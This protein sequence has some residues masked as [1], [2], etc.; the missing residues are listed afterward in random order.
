MASFITALL[1]HRRL[2]SAA[3]VLSLIC[4][5]YSARTIQV[6]FQFRDFYDH[7]SNPL[8][9]MFKQH[10]EEFGDPAGY[11]VAMVEADDVFRRDILEYVRAVT[12]ALEPV[13]EYAQVISLSNTNAIR[14]DGDDVKTGPLLHEMPS[15]DAELQKLKQTVLSDPTLVRRLVSADGKATAILA[16]MRVPAAFANTTEQRAAIAGVERALAQHPAP[17]G[18]NVRLTGAPVLEAGT[19]DVLTRD[20]LILTPIVCF[21]LGLMLFWTFR[22]LHGVLLCLASVTAAT[23]WAAGIFATFH[24]PIDVLGSIIPTT[25]LV[26]GVVDPIFVLARFLNKLD[27]G[28]SQRDAIVQSY[29]ELGLPCF[30]TS[31]ATAIGFA[32]FVTSVSPGIRYYGLT[33]AIGVMLTFVTTVTVL[34][35]LLWFVPAPKQRFNAVTSTKHVNAAL[36]WMWTKVSPRPWTASLI[37]C[38][39]LVGLGLLAK[40]QQVSN[41]YINQLAD[42]PLR[43]DV[44]AFEDKLTGVIRAAVRLEAGPDDFKKPEVLQA[45]AKLQAAIARD[46]L[47]TFIA[48]PADLVANTHRAFQGG[49]PAAREV[50]SSRTLTAQ[51]LA[52]ID[53]KDRAPL[54]NSDY[55]HAQILIVMKDRGSASVREFAA[56]LERTVQAADLSSVGVRPIITG[57]SIMGYREMDRLVQELLDGFVIAFAVAILLQ[58]I[59]F[60]S[61]RVALISI[62]PN[63]LPLT[64]GFCVTRLS[65][66]PLRFDS[67]LVLCVAIGGLFNTTIHL[68]SRVQ[69]QVSN[70]ARDPDQIVLTALR[71]VGTPSLITAVTLSAGFVMFTLSEFPG[72]RML[73]VL[74]MLTF[75]VGFVSDVVF[76]SAMLRIGFD[77]K[78]RI[79]KAED[80]QP[81]YV[82]ST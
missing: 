24:R 59:G 41:Q 77:W 48:S 7:P 61:L 75:M 34:P 35:L 65:G 21:V 16:E 3:L 6:R 22:S 49:D 47:V 73:G 19:T 9:A 60:R 63:L 74:S 57:M 67:A 53:P 62:V 43:R 29:R 14:G 17:R 15:T 18:V 79:R 56:Q 58:W 25:I 54:V 52:L 38:A 13:P 42:G 76:T 12:K 80:V 36:T 81:A 10:N 78:R 31:T 55:S 28:L 69:Q 44:H 71:A 8:L 2:A 39:L 68:A 23:V 1:R 32:A 27:D 64:I 45:V 50:P 82:A 26:Y 72:L 4:A 33:V 40:D 11:V 66:T 51:Y 20:Q 30:L 46:P 70:G 5:A 37:A